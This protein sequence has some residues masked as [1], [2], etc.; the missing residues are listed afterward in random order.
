MI[1]NFNVI[2]LHSKN[3]FISY[4][5]LNVPLRREEFYIEFEKEEYAKRAKE[6]SKNIENINVLNSLL[7]SH[8]II[9]HC[10]VNIEKSTIFETFIKYGP[11][12][13]IC[14][15]KDVTTYESQKTPE[16]NIPGLFFD[17]CYDYSNENHSNRSANKYTTNNNASLSA[18]IYNI[19]MWLPWKFITNLG[20]T[21]KPAFVATKKLINNSGFWK[22]KLETLYNTKLPDKY[23][24]W[25]FMHELFERHSPLNVIGEYIANIDIVTVALELNG[26]K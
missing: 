14:D 13:K 16:V 10:L 8:V 21:C 1:Y 9:A 24:R 26:Y 19:G 2:N 3:M 4:Y 7:Y 23:I 6:S 12:I 20:Y 15:F 22:C 25:S 5:P 17:L 11:I 18:C